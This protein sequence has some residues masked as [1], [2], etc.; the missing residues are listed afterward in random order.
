MEG[1]AFAS[2]TVNYPAEVLGFFFHPSNIKVEND[3]AW[4]IWKCQG[5]WRVMI[6]K[7]ISENFEKWF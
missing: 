7:K 4:M 6:K 5:L 1:G 3:S 2:K